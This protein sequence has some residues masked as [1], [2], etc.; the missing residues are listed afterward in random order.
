M[1]KFKE[2]KWDEL[3][4]RCHMIGAIMTP[5]KDA[6]RKAAGEFG[7]TALIGLQKIYILERFGREQKLDTVA[8]N[9]GLGVESI[10]IEMIN[11][12][13]GENYKKN[14]ERVNN[15]WFSGIPDM[16]KGTNI[17]KSKVVRDHKGN[18]DLFSFLPNLDTKPTM[19]EVGKPYW[20]QGQSY[21]DICNC[22]VFYLDYTLQDMPPALLYGEM[23]KLGWKMGI[24]TDED[25]EYKKAVA[26]LEF[27]LTYGDIPDELKHISIK[28][29]RNEDD[30]QAARYAVERARKYLAAFDERFMSRY[31][32]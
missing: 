16:W 17:Y 9:K 19:S 8:I 24:A 22:P 20:Y 23:R 7:D 2:I 31:K 30:I 14:E 1:G 26:E 4:I 28:I 13:T 21:M 10:G 29:E 32:Q 6:A 5:P 15:K 27:N 3:L 12:L 18:Y 25:P 11:R